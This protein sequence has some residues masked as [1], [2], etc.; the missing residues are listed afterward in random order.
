MSNN[1]NQKIFFVFKIWLPSAVVV[2]LACSLIYLTVQQNYRTNAG[3]P[4]IQLAQDTARFLS[5]QA[6]LSAIV[7]SLNG[8]VEMDKSL[9]PFLAVYD[10]DGK[11]LKSSGMISGKTPDLPKGV[12]D[13][14]K[15]HN[16]S[17]F[18][19][20]PQKGVRIA[21]VLEKFSGNSQGF[22]LAGR[23]LKEVEK[24]ETNLLLEV[25]MGFVAGLVG[26]LITAIFLV[27]LQTFL[28]KN[29]KK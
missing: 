19:W 22:V 20:E 4:Q 1:L 17:T 21:A 23:S 7:E 13:Y 11:L 14:T 2:A 27:F 10:K 16:E 18:T 5:D 8:N 28:F 24:R 15:S 6:D 9:A 25:G 3:D 26:T 12:F 29:V